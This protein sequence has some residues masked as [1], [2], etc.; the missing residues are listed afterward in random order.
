MSKETFRLDILITLCESLRKHPDE[1]M[2]TS[3]FFKDFLTEFFSKYPPKPA[4]LV[5]ALKVIRRKDLFPLRDA[6]CETLRRMPIREIPLN[7]IN[8][9]RESNNLWLKAEGL[10]LSRRRL[11]LMRLRISLSGRRKSFSFTDEE[12]WYLHQVF[13]KE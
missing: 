3:D 10:A 11:N 6:L 8:E 2:R 7:L 9:L 4:S 1:Y 12:I 5:E 13:F